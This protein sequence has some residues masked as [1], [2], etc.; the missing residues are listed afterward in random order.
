MEKLKKV[1]MILGIVVVAGGLAGLSYY[2]YESFYYFSTQDAQ[3]TSDMITLTPEITG[4]LK[5]WDVKEGD[6]VKAGQVLGKQEVGSLVSSSAMNPQSMTNSADSIIAKADIKSPIDGKVV[7]SNVIKGEVI[8]PGMEI[9][10]IADTSRF[11]IKAN[12]E[13]TDIFKVKQGQQVD[14]DIDAYPGRSFTGFV[15]S[16]GQATNSAFNTMPSLNTS[17]TYS[18]V[19]QLI[20]VRITLVDVD[21]LVLMPGMNATVKIHVK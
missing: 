2:I 21:K 5:S 11:Y 12:I 10:T 13:E 1:L 20:P 14:I 7:K 3:V 15:E 16:I 18:K 4:K 6:Y 8:S 19:T 9:A 17:G